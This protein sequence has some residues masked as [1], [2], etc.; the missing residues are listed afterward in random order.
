M[1]VYHACGDVGAPSHGSHEAN[2]GKALPCSQMQERPTRRREVLWSNG[3]TIICEMRRVQ[4][5]GAS[6]VP[7]HM[8]QLLSQQDGSVFCIWRGKQR[9]D[10]SRYPRFSDC[11]L[12]LAGCLLGSFSHDKRKQLKKLLLGAREPYGEQGLTGRLQR[13]VGRLRA[14]RCGFGSA[15]SRA[16]DSTFLSKPGVQYLHTPARDR[17]GTTQ[18]VKL[19]TKARER[20]R[21]K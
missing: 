1:G 16:H 3:A 13:R 19:L 4:V 21:K 7:H 10:L 14:R 9:H 2:H 5:Q 8:P 18:D 12:R 20:G 15:L 17:L 6:W 11:W